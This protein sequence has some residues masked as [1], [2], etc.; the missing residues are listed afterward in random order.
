VSSRIILDIEANGLNPDKIFCIVTADVDSGQLKS[1][2]PDM[3]N[4]FN[5]DGVK[6]IIG[7]NILGYDIP[8]LERL[9]DLDFSN[10]KLTD[11]LVLS[12]LFNP[13][14]DGGH[15][16]AAWGQRLGYPKGDHTDFTQFTDEMLE[17]CERD[18]QVNIKTY[19]KLMIESD[20]F[21]EESI[22]LEMD[23]H[24][25]I[26]EQSRTGWLLDEYRAL[27]LL[28][29]LKE[30]K[31]E[32]EDKVHERFTPLPI[33]VEKN[34]PK[35]PYKKDGTKAAVL[36]RHEEAGYHYNKAGSY[37]RTEYPEFN[38]G[39]RQQIGR[40]LMHYGWQPKEFTQTGLPKV[41]EKVL[42]SVEIP[43]AQLIAQYLLVQK[44]IA[45]V[46]SWVE[47]VENDGRVHGYV[48]PIG[49][50]TNRMSHSSPNLAQ[51]PASYSPYGKECRQC[52]TV[53]K[54][55]KL[56]GCDASGLE[57]RMLASYMN[58]EA[59]TNEV[60]N[61]DI[62]TANQIA[63][64]LPDRSQAKVF[65][66]GFLYGAGDAKIGEIV[67]GTAKEGKRLK[68]K[69]LD[70]IP[71][72]KRL[73]EQVIKAAGRGYIKG[74][75]R[76]KVWIKEDYSALNYL[77]QSAGSIVMKKALVILDQQ[78]KERNLD[79]KFVGNIH[80][81]FQTEVAEEH[82]DEFGKLAV[83]AIIEAGVQ[84]NMKCPLDGEYKIGTDW[85]ETH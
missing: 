32:L 12:R 40:Y 75:D 25:I 55:Y 17:Y 13:V 8:V 58:D 76:R 36:L 63:A 52:W 16:L 26:N 71:A 2:T 65:I 81:E 72:L 79:Y 1:Y 59:Y 10:I 54:G 21:S 69:F 14:R 43:E 67:G 78:A 64:G 3:I 35:N 38:L 28:A 42:E 34:Y 53:P 24:K 11:T 18:V 41:D 68:K 70:A 84:L 57:L 7:H 47:A 5:L 73:R 15:S 4:Q 74:L 6:E 77:L 51:V 29:E 60:I 27:D 46:Q 83:N 23:V 45:Q 50:Q 31:M 37:G 56:V 22:Q 48:N 19:K 44:R 61:G 20:G 85:S 30:K 82:A 33:W 62:H 39:S 66:Y 49:A 80:D 9:L